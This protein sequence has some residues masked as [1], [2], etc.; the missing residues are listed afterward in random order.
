MSIQFTIPEGAKVYLDKPYVKVFW[1]PND[2]IL[3][4][5]WN[6]FSTYD[7]IIA[8]GKRILEATALENAIKVLCDARGL[9]VL[10]QDS[11]EYISKSF[12]ADM[13]AAGVKFAAT[14][15]PEDLLAKFSVD[16]IK[17][18]QNDNKEVTVLYFN[19]ISK[20]I[21]WLKKM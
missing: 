5:F 21:N 6:G 16:E 4:S 2:K 7:E 10:D 13:K 18:T 12:T 15:I 17:K 14:V 3:S 8:I 20:A 19:S 1:N 11:L 9:E